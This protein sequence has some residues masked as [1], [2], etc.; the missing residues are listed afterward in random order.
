[1]RSCV[2]STFA[3]TSASRNQRVPTTGNSVLVAAAGSARQSS[4]RCPPH[5]EPCRPVSRL[6]TALEGLARALSGPKAASARDRGPLQS[7]RTVLVALKASSQWVCHASR[8][9]PGER[10]TRQSWVTLHGQPLRLRC[11][12]HAHAQTAAIWHSAS[13]PCASPH[14]ATVG[15]IGRRL[16]TGVRVRKTVAKLSHASGYWRQPRQFSDP[17]DRGFD[18]GRSTAY[19]ACLHR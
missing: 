18:T 9:S 15:Y 3:A 19:F 10:A 13:A 4:P 8:A 1:V 5:S 14:D 6:Q 2:C 12:Q 11:P 16:R 17:R 7:H